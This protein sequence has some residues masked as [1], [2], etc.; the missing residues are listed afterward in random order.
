ME[1]KNLKN[2]LSTFY[3]LATT[4]MCPLQMKKVH[5]THHYNDNSNQKP[6]IKPKNFHAHAVPHCI[7]QHAQR[8]KYRYTHVI[9]H[10][11]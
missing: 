7:N 4:N 10:I 6:T 8:N 9:Q 11:N 1:N 2:Q 5:K 3:Y